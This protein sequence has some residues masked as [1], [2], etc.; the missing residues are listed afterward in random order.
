MNECM[1]GEG[2]FE[3]LQHAMYSVSQV[4]KETIG[5]FLDQNNFIFSVSYHP[6]ISD[7][8]LARLDEEDKTHIITE[9]QAQCQLSLPCH[10]S[11]N[12]FLTKNHN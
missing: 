10:A 2:K 1:N 4:D 5:C 12:F 7:F 6:K 9:W 3:V 11:C 8:G